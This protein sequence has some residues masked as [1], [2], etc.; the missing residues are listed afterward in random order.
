MIRDQMID[1][2]TPRSAM[3]RVRRL[4]DRA[5]PAPAAQAEEMKEL[6]DIMERL[7]VKRAKERHSF[8]FKLL[9]KESRLE[10]SDCF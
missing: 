9:R 2:P 1:C 3:T 5:G 7:A 6:T 8:V 4:R 10:G